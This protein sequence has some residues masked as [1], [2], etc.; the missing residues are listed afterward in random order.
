[1]A[2]VSG[3]VVE[4]P[5]GKPLAGVFVTMVLQQYMKEGFQRGKGYCSAIQI[6]QTDADGRYAFRWDWR[7]KGMDI[8]DRVDASV[9]LY[10]PGMNYW[11]RQYSL[12]YLPN[13]RPV[14][15][16][17]RDDASFEDRLSWLR[18]ITSG[19][20]MVHLYGPTLAAMLRAIHAEYWQL[21]CDPVGGADTPLD[22]KTYEDMER[23]LTGLHG[24]ASLKLFRTS[25]EELRIHNWSERK[26]RIRNHAPTY[27]WAPWRPWETPPEPR[28]L[29]PV[30]KQQLCA[31][32]DPKTLD[33]RQVP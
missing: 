12:Y 1:V 32:L 20:C 23:R 33:W 21:Y 29:T 24:Y 3:T 4:Y 9:V 27:P 8:P 15:Q 30:E 11:P 10:A 19:S 17:F 7:A 28:D 25:P 5:S 18:S 13:R 31:A 22:Y 16:L 2:E 26:T 6:A 14:V